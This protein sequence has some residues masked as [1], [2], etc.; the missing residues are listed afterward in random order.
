MSKY[1]LAASLTLCASPMAVAQ[2]ETATEGTTETIQVWGR[3]FDQIGQAQSATEGLVGY[4]DIATRPIARVGELVEVIPGMIATQHSGTGKANQYFLRGFNLDHGTDFAAYIDG[5]P[6]NMRSHGHGQGYLDLNPIIPEMVAEIRYRKGSYRADDGDFS[7]AGSARFDFYDVLPENFATLE[8]GEYG[9]V[10]TAAGYSH[11]T[12]HGAFTL[13]GERVT[14]DGPWSVEEDAER[15][16]LL[17]RYSGTALGGDTSLTVMYYDADWRG[18]DQLPERAIG[19]IGRFGV[20]DPD[21]GG[22][23]ERLSL[24]GRWENETAFVDAYILRSDFTLFSNF[25][26]LLE[27]PVNGDQF[28]QRDERWVMG[29]RYGQTA[30]LGD[31]FTLNWGADV[32]HDDIGEIGLYRSTARQRTGTIRADE[33][34]ETSLSAYSELTWR[35]IETLRLTGGLRADWMDVEVNALTLADNGG[36][37][38]DSLISPK[39]GAAWQVAPTIELYANYGR[40]FHSNDARGVTIQ[41]DPVSGD[42]VDGVPLIVKGD[43]A[44]LGARWETDTLN[45]TV[46]AFWLELDSELV[47]VGDGGATEPNDGTERF[48]LEAALFW[49]VNDWL[50]AD[51]EAAWTDAAFQG[52]GADDQIPG[53][54]ETVLSGGLAASWNNLSASARVRHFG[55]APL[56][57]DG[58]VTSDPTTLVNIGGAYALGDMVLAVDVFNLFDSADADITYFYESRLSGEAAG[59]EDRHLRS[60][61]PRQLRAS[62]T[63]HF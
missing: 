38:D 45:V 8:L 28:E 27:D 23:S 26:Y 12:A 56:I 51:V 53:A 21:L 50:V 44:E 33:I 7:L 19:S 25:T 46:A 41:L 3:A 55:E 49:Q 16:N 18:A 36:T 1:L 35:P 24:T 40:G 9:H 6:V 34:T 15:L 42:A 4:D 17:A 29:A 37:G 43:G 52:V 47:F 13:G 22:A 10:R 62:V 54:V 63:W 31:H 39:L 58:S 14:Y 57:E 5:A 61:E 48:G 11:E 20:V 2:S 32:R 60:V 59:V 30:P